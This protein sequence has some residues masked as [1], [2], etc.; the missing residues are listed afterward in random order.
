MIYMWICIFIIP[1]ERTARLLSITNSMPIFTTCLA[2]K[3]WTT[4][5]IFINTFSTLNH[6]NIKL[7]ISNRFGNSTNYETTQSKDCPKF[8]IRSLL[9]RPIYF[10][11]FTTLAVRVPPPFSFFFKW[12]TPP[13][14]SNFLFPRGLQ[15]YSLQNRFD[16]LN[17][18]FMMMSKLLRIIWK[19]IWPLV[20]LF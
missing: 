2:I 7:F 20:W 5:E 1:T 11:V 15:K 17:H 4:C 6:K 18:S 19:S 16:H 8:H 12:K 10:F 13:F 14:N 3:F 9:P